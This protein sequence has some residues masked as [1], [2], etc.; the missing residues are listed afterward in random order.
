MRMKD[1]NMKLETQNLATLVED[2]GAQLTDEHHEKMGEILSKLGLF[3]LENS[4]PQPLDVWK[5]I[6]QATADHS[7]YRIVW[8][9]PVLGSASIAVYRQLATSDP[10]FWVREG[11]PISGETVASADHVEGK[12]R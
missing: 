5:G 1:E 3:D 9:G 7:G 4:P 2:V 12:N 6:I 10:T 8:E 11:S